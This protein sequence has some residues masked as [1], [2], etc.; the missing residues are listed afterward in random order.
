MKLIFK[1]NFTKEQES[2]LAI[3]SE[4]H[5]IRF[6][7]RPTVDYYERKIAG[8]LATGESTSARLSD[9]QVL[10]EA[11]NSVLNKA[12]NIKSLVRRLVGEKNQ[13]VIDSLLSALEDQIKG[14]DYDFTTV[15]P[16]QALVNTQDKM[17]DV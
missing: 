13:D 9:E 17:E 3:C 14:L 16:D 6:M 15:K 7:D 10:Q 11:Y 5:S 12:D 8:L 4:L 2:L 1:R